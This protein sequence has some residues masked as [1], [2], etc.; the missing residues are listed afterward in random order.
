MLVPALTPKPSFTCRLA[1]LIGVLAV[2][3]PISGCHD[4][5]LYA[6]K[7]ANPYYVMG[8]WKQDK[9]R[10]VTDYQRREELIDLADSIGT[11]PAD[12]QQVWAEHLGALLEND[13]SPEM[14]RLAIQTAGNLNAVPS[15]ALIEKGLDDDSVKVRMEACRALASK[16]TMKSDQSS[17]AVRMLASTIGTETNDDVR[18]AAISAL[19]NHKSPIA[20]D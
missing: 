4:G 3:G 7:A 11:M 1:V 14:R 17:E 8:D 19:A 16:T 15:I 12:R 10:G 5:P 20:V 6:I 9:E 18:N 2:I 13:Q